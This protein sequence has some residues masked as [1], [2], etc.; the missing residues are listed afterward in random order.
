MQIFLGDVNVKK[1][2]LAIGIILILFGLD[3]AVLH[4]FSFASLAYFLAGIV[5]IVYSRFFD[6]VTKLVHLII[7]VLYAIPIVMIAF[8]AIYGSIHTTDFTEDV[9][10]VL[11]AGLRND[12]IM[13]SL[14]ARLEQALV[15]FEYN[16][17]AVFVVCGGYGEGQTISEARAMADFLIAGGVPSEQIILEDLSTS[18]YEN[19][20]FALQLL[21][22]Y[23]PDGFSSV[24][25]TNN[26]HMYRS[27]YIASYLGLDPARF[28]APTPFLTW[29]RNYLREVIAVFNT[30]LFQ[31]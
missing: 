15:Y 30:W 22:E 23:F 2:F 27:G 18:T 28:G 21:D 8:L 16:S 10:F 12:E 1:I 29:H 26:F 11:G 19:F 14:E 13:P 7:G 20:D 25:V 4:H 6:T 9:V 3:V 31:T 17:N 5:L 24:V